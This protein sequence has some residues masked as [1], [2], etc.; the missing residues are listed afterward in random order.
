MTGED[1]ALGVARGDE[2]TGHDA[3]GAALQRPRGGDIGDEVVGRVA[4]DGEDRE[5]AA[6]GE[7]LGGH[8]DA[9]AVGRGLDPDLGRGD[10]VGELVA[11]PGGR[12]AAPGGDRDVDGAGR[13]G[14]GAVALIEV[15]ELTVKLVALVA[16]NLT[17]VAPV[18]FV[19][20]IVTTVPPVVGP[21]F[22]LTGVTVGAAT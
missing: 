22:G 1:R 2:I 6:R 14:R 3:A 13:A 21:E 4:A 8:D 18:K 12:G 19:P 16:P 5:R 15:A 7:A 17:A 10:D 9:R 11:G 20:V